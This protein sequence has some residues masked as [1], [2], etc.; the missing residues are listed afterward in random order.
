MRLERVRLQNPPGL[1]ESPRPLAQRRARVPT[2][3]PADAHLASQPAL[4]RLDVDPREYRRRLRTAHK[5]GVRAIRRVRPRLML[6][7]RAPSDSGQRPQSRP[8]AGVRFAGERDDY[9]KE[10]AARVETQPGGESLIK[11][12]TNNVLSV[13]VACSLLWAFY[14]PTHPTRNSNREHAVMH[15]SSSLIPLQ[16]AIFTHSRQRSGH[17][18]ECLFGKL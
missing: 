15:L 13:G 1:A 17:R 14:T 18:L 16:P 12:G 10:D 5:K 2:D 3:P 4:S 9:G 11:E 7:A 8:P 6:R